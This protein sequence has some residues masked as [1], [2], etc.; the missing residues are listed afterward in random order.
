MLAILINNILER[1]LQYVFKMQNRDE[2]F[3][4]N[5]YQEGGTVPGEEWWFEFVMNSSWG[6]GR[7]KTSKNMHK[8][9]GLCTQGY[10]S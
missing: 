1:Q 9:Q 10:V 6:G 5:D 7:E 3:S 4:R 2:V 8:E